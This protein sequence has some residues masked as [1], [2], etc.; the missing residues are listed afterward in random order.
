MTRFHLLGAALLVWLAVPSLATAQIVTGGVPNVDDERLYS[1]LD[2]EDFIGFDGIAETPLWP[3]KQGDLDHSIWSGWDT[4]TAESVL[5]MTTT[6]NGLPAVEFYDSVIW[7]DPAPFGILDNFDEGFT[8]FVVATVRDASRAYFFTG[9]QGG[10][11]AEANANYDPG[12]V[13]IEQDYWSIA[14]DDDALRIQTAP[15]DVDEL[16]YHAFTFRN[17]GMASHYLMGTLAGEGEVDAATMSGIVLGGRQNGAQRAGVDFAEV[18]I[19]T[20]GLDDA[21]RQAIEGYFQ[22]KYFGG[23]VVLPGDYN[24]DGMVDTADIDLQAMAMKTPTENLAT[25]DENNDGLVDEKDRIIWVQQ[26]A[27]TWFGDANFDG[28]FTSDDLVAVFAAGKYETSQSATWVEGDWSGDEVFDSADLVAAFS[29]GGFE[30]GPRPAVSA[31][32]EPS[33][34]ALL[35]VGLISLARR[36]P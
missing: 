15:V 10:G 27:K 4:A 30:L 3:N 12:G 6:D 26:H 35:L 21:D 5:Q 8:I 7:S 28:S 18:M 1:W 32:P 13:G 11:G 29:D 22:T 33:S 2:A 9:N 34:I 20:T 36:R 25:Y 23:G 14:G 16:Q 19:Y 31:V 17:D 24:E